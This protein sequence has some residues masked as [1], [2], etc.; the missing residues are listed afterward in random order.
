MSRY[1]S[2]LLSGS[3]ASTRSP[4]PIASISFIT[5][6]ASTTASWPAS[7][8]DGLPPAS[9]AGVEMSSGNAVC[10]VGTRS[11]P[12]AN[13]C[14]RH[15]TPTSFSSSP[16]TQNSARWPNRVRRS[17]TSCPTGSKP[18]SS[19]PCSAIGDFFFNKACGTVRITAL[20][21]LGGASFLRLLPISGRSCATAPVPLWQLAVIC[22]PARVD[23]CGKASLWNRRSASKGSSG[24]EK[25]AR[26]PGAPSSPPRARFLPPEL[27]AGGAGAGHSAVWS[28][29]RD[30]RAAAC[31]RTVSARV[32]RSR[33]QVRDA[34]SKA[35]ARNI[36]GAPLPRAASN[37][38]R[39]PASLGRVSSWCGSTTSGARSHGCSAS[40][41]RKRRNPAVW[42]PGGTAPPGAVEH[43][44]T[45]SSTASSATV[46]SIIMPEIQRFAS[47]A[48]A[49]N[50]GCSP[51]TS[52]M[53]PWC[54]CRRATLLDG[55]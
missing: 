46:P 55:A 3:T 32:G 17:P 1:S 40:S 39:M 9:S 13:A 41:A 27:V 21:S 34:G 45:S 30:R 15:L 53:A 16:P 47:L 25:T 37:T 18:T 19:S 5:D 2:A 43:A 24:A 50:A 33:V 11:G 14:G 38:S 4:S 51:P 8:L 35:V 31:R 22:A 44:A 23:S 28:S 20:A 36:A 6:A 49:A 52:A 42:A 54:H 48:V 12:G 29:D 26:Q 10:A 7:A